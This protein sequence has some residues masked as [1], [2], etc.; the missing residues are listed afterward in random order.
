METRMN[1]FKEIENALHS[2]ISRNPSALGVNSISTCVVNNIISFL[3]IKGI[4]KNY[5]EEIDDAVLFKFLME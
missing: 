2:Y 5:H 4:L 1:K 3:T